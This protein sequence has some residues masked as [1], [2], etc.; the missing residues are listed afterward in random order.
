M[1]YVR[2]VCKLSTI[3]TCTWPWA[4]TNSKAPC[5]QLISLLL[6]RCAFPWEVLHSELVSAGMRKLFTTE[7][8]SQ[9]LL[10]PILPFGFAP[11]GPA[12]PTQCLV[13][14]AEQHPIPPTNMISHIPTPL[15]KSRQLTLGLHSRAERKT[16]PT[17]G[18]PFYL[19]CLHLDS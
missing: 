1:T 14:F 3:F 10:Y 16:N 4:E 5:Y 11:A 8:C 15:F 12:R 17:R 18:A 9:L 2:S 7:E 13:S 19:E 6:A